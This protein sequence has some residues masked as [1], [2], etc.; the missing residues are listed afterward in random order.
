V[1]KHLATLSLLFAWLC[2]N[3][4]L[5]DVAQIFAWSR[6]FTEYARVLPVSAALTETFDAS[7]PCELCLAV[8]ETRQADAKQSPALASSAEKLLLS[9]NATAPIVFTP[10]ATDWPAAIHWS[11]CTRVDAVPVP[12]PRA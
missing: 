7:K 1:R 4:A 9:C 11:L 12:P 2:A 5:S 8:K 3:G 10:P 6:M